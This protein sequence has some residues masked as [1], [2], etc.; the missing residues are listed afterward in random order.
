MIYRLYDDDD[1]GSGQRTPH[2][3][4]VGQRLPGILHSFQQ[5][6][7]AV[8]R[9]VS[10]FSS[11]SSPTSG[12]HS[13]EK[14]V[15][16]PTSPR[17][18][19]SD[20][21]RM[22]GLSGDSAGLKELTTKLTNVVLDE[23]ETPPATPRGTTSTGS[24]AFDTTAPT[25]AGSS[26]RP[27]RTPSTTNTPAPPGPKLGAPRGKL[28]VKLHEARN[29]ITMGMPYVVCTFEN[30][31]FISKG[32]TIEEKTNPFGEHAGKPIP[33]KTMAIPMRSTSSPLTTPEL[34]SSGG[35]KSPTWGQEAVL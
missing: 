15:S 9:I 32:P 30:N 25:S 11:R 2:I 28:I 24:I 1:T 34:G 20:S 6:C 26:E 7:S 10:Q 4:A 31:E 33:A 29:L 5:V 19:S 22:D 23:K 17:N 16:C 14:S 35:T 3:G 12:S 8:P 18:A 21:L 27:S 13:K